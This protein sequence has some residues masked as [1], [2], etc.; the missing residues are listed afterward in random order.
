LLA[1]KKRAHTRGVLDRV[2]AWLLKV[3]ETLCSLDSA[4]RTQALVAALRT[5]AD[6]LKT[7]T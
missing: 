7:I 6:V 5:G 3:E 4:A 1:L 2:D